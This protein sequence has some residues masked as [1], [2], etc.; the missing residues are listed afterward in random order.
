M[1]KNELVVLGLLREKPMH[2][3]QLYQEIERREMEHWAQVN[4]ASIYNTLSRLQ[5]NKLIQ[6]KEERP[7]KMPERRVYH[8]TPKGKKRLV[9]LVEMALNEQKMPQ[10]SFM[11]G[12]AFLH[13][14]SKGKV[15]DS[16]SKKKEHLHNIIHRVKKLYHEVH[17][18]V[19]FNWRFIFQEGVSHLKTHIELV[20]KLMG[21]VKRYK[22]F[23][24]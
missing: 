2:G 23:E 20:E 15:L 8:I 9:E 18:D 24:K 7:G 3:Y 11:V 19:P 16:L 6:G 12:V 5:R 10:D 1:T 13:V 4:L 22:T 17:K 14:L 21:Q